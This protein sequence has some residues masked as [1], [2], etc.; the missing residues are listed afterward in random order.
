M[1]LVWATAFYLRKG[2]LLPAFRITK[3]FE[4]RKKKA[5]NNKELQE[6]CEGYFNSLTTGEPLDCLIEE[7]DNAGFEVN[8]EIS[9]IFR[10]VNSEKIA[11]KILERMGFRE[12]DFALR[13]SEALKPIARKAAVVFAEEIRN[14]GDAPRDPL[15]NLASDIMRKRKA[16]AMIALAMIAGE[17]ALPVLAESAE[18]SDPAVRFAAF[19]AISRINSPA[20]TRLLTKY[21]YA[22]NGQWQGD[23]IRLLPRLD[24]AVAIPILGKYFHMSPGK[25]IEIIRTIGRLGGPQARDFLLD[26]LDSW[27]FYYNEIDRSDADG[28]ILALLDSLGRCPYDKELE[29]A[30][31]LFIGE[32]R[33]NNIVRGVKDIFGV[34]P[35]SVIKE[36]KNIISRWKEEKSEVST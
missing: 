5:Y 6:D 17:L 7:L 31:K 9:E 24:S 29:R 16:G 13:A 36:A 11:E 14:I 12:R 2:R 20:A 35:D 22:Q 28:F 4:V 8:Q 21:L 26:T 34:N 10:I 3:A 1:F 33:G 15:G 23:V 19:E 18:D 30:V 25:W 32:W 27:S